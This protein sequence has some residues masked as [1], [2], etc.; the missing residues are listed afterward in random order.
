MLKKWMDSRTAVCSGRSSID[1][2]RSRIADDLFRPFE[3]LLCVLT[4]DSSCSESLGG[5]GSVA[6][7]PGYTQFRSNRSQ[8]EQVGS[9]S[10]HYL[11]I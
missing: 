4:D 2:L 10:E 6:R 7:L 5:V 11:S 1:S 3:R 9:V 8:L